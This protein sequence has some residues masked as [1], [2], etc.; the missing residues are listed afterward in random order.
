MSY[1]PQLDKHSLGTWAG[2]EVR[3]GGLTKV[4]RAHVGCS[5][6]VCHWD[7]CEGCESDDLKER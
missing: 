5:L 7:E 3:K 1:V 2:A 6:S 4:G